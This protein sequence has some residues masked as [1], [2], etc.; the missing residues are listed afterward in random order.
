MEN[1]RVQNILHGYCDDDVKDADEVATP[2]T[3]QINSSMSMAMGVFS[4]SLLEA[5]EAI[6]PVMVPLLVLVTV[7]VAV[8][9][10]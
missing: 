6:R 3:I 8:L 9:F 7:P 10:K 5:S 1:G 4:F 2:A